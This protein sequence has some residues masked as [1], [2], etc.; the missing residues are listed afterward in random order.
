MVISNE[1]RLLL[2]GRT[3]R[4]ATHPREG[5]IRFGSYLTILAAML[6]YLRTS[7]FLSDVQPHFYVAFFGFY[8]WSRPSETMRDRRL[9]PALALGTSYFALMLAVGD[10]TLGLGLLFLPVFTVMLT[11]EDRAIM[12]RCFKTA[13][14]VYALGCVAEA[15]GFSS[16][17]DVLLAETRTSQSRGFHSLTNEPSYL[18]VVGLALLVYAL[19]SRQAMG[20]VILTALVILASGSITGIGPAVLV[21]IVFVL[22]GR[23]LKRL[24]ASVVVVAVLALVGSA[25]IDSGDRLAQVSTDLWSSPTSVFDDVSAANR[26]SRSIGPGYAALIDGFQ[27]HLQASDQ[28]VYVDFTFLT[29]DSDRSFSRAS[30]LFSILTYVLGWLSLPLL[31]ATALTARGKAFMWVAA[32]YFAL[33]NVSISTP[34]VAVVFALLFMTPSRD[35]RGGAA[36]ERRVGTV[37]SD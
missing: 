2:D 6:P 3:R 37:H 17:L 14:S 7:P 22:S 19:W 26:I 32:T 29:A 30:N 25:M 20:W 16:I 15:S 36:A 27:P 11:H 33:T 23:S 8:V 24:A 35:E 28:V 13:T 21:V 34:Y 5:V 9:P 1:G 31:L 10:P 4:Q 18:A 12:D